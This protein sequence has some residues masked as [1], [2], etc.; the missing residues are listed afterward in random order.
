[1]VPDPKDKLQAVGD[2]DRLS[3]ET[4]ELLATTERLLKEM[5]VLTE[6][7]QNLAA[8][9]AVPSEKRTKKGK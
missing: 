1:M 9:R 7:A 2:L 5:Q 4:D 3:Q 8:L 6:D